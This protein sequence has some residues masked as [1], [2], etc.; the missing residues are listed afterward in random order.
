[1]AHLTIIENEPVLI[2]KQQLSNIQK[3]QLVKQ[4]YRLIWA[5]SAV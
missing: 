5:H 1:M 2:E 4:G 3:A